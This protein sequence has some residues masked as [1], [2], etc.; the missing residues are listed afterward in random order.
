M[1]E[2][3]QCDGTLNDN[4]L[5]TS[6][7]SQIEA[8]GESGK[9][10]KKKQKKQLEI[11]GEEADELTKYQPLDLKLLT[12]KP[13]G[14]NQE[15]DIW[16]ASPSDFHAYVQQYAK[17]FSKVNVNIWPLAERLALV[18]FLW[19]YCQEHGY[20]FP[21]RQHLV[22]DVDENTDKSAPEAE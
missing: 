7:L 10:G 1:S 16:H 5:N 20:S 9:S 18:N 17:G 14:S 4:I 21:F 6:P 13:I 8:Q 19:K 12:F 15:V 3:P 2:H 11:E 22:P